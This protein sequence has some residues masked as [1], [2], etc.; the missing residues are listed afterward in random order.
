MAEIEPHTAAPLID[1]PC[2]FPIK[3][4]GETHSTF[5]DIIIGLIQTILPEFS[6][7]QV[8]S[9]VSSTGKYT[10]LT[11]TVHVVSQAQLDSIYRLISAHP[12]VKYSL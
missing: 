7:A 8:E 2:D 6:A 5:S 1:F 3:V 10:S 12:L 11:C 4:M 9:R